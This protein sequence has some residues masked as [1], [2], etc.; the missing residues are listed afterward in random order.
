MPRSAR[1]FCAEAKRYA[2]EIVAGR[3]VA[4]QWVRSACERHLKDLERRGWKY[5]F[6]ERSAGKVCQFIENLPHTKGTWKTS[7]ILLESWQCFV[8]CVLFGWVDAETGKRRFRTAYIEVPRKNAKSTL[9]SG[10]GL[11]LL[12]EDGEPGAEVYSA[13]TTRDQAKIVFNAAQEMARRTPE[14]REHYGLAV[15]AHNIH[16]VATGSKFEALSSEGNTL[17]GLNIHGCAVDELHAHPSRDVWDVL[18][19]ATGART[20][21]LI[22]AITTAGSDKTGICYEQRSYVTK[23]LGGAV[24]DDSYFGIIYTID[25]GDDWRDAESWKK[26]NPNFGVSVIPDDIERAAKFAIETPAA[27]NN[28]LTK[29]LN[30]WV[31]ADVGL[32]DMRAWQECGVQGLRESDFSEFPCWIGVDLGFVDDI[33]SVVKVYRAESGPHEGKLAVFGRHYLPEAAVA[34]SRNSQYSGWVRMGRIIEAGERET[35]EAAIVEGLLNDFRDLRVQLVAF[36]PWKRKEITG[37]LIERGI[38]EEMLIDFPQTVKFMSP[39]TESLMKSV[40]GRGI[41]HDGDPV[42]S[43]AMSNV[44]GHFDAA[45][46]VRPEKE[47]KDRKIDPAIA[48][49]MAHYRARLTESGE[50]VYSRRGVIVL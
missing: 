38:R 47:A 30:V 46:N 45:G 36:D 43:W 35:D 42:L 37:P 5:L 28:F 29:R 10:I 44:V 20:Q 3:I 41:V 32:F 33:A 17:D 27:V 49:I 2:G 9:S 16:V 18:I 50:S 25:E 31:N 8:L 13:A 39:A 1:E 4:C 15:N 11:F 26:A 21:S 34:A 24:E 12:A 40:L 7:T 14:L 23:V 6:D 48:T 22:W 19:S